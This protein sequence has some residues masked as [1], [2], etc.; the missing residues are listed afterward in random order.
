MT[1]PSGQAPLLAFCQ[2]A[3]KHRVQRTDLQ[4]HFFGP[5]VIDLRLGSAVAKTDGFGTALARL[6]GAAATAAAPLVNALGSALT[7]VMNLA[8]KRAYLA[9]LISLLTGK[10]LSGMQQQPRR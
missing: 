3:E 10:S 5:A 4:R 1:V 2:T 6:K 7:Y 9:K 8:A